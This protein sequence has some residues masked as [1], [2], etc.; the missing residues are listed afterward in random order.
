MPLT[1]LR[2]WGE[3]IIINPRVAIK[4]RDWPVAWWT[5]FE[6]NSFSWTLLTLALAVR[7]KHYHDGKMRRCSHALIEHMTAL[8]Y[9]MV[10]KGPEESYTV[11]SNKIYS[12][13]LATSFYFNS[14]DQQRARAALEWGVFHSHCSASCLVSFFLLLI[15]NDFTDILLNFSLRICGGVG[16][17][18]CCCCGL[19]LETSQKVLT[20]IEFFC[21]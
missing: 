4:S 20:K 3:K 7:R 2:K 11:N 9:G 14:P 1:R 15:I 17:P 18:V 13:N 8:S 12:H 16:K 10:L 19:I 21:L 5:L 6:L